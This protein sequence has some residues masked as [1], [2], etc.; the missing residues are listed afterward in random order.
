MRDGERDR[1]P[2]QPWDLVNE[3]AGCVLERRVDRRR[4]EH[5]TRPA[6]LSRRVSSRDLAL[7]IKDTLAAQEVACILAAEF[8]L[9][10]GRLYP[11]ANVGLGS[12]TAEV[13]V[14]LLE[15]Y[16][17]PG[18]NHASEGVHL[19]AILEAHCDGWDL[20]VEV[21]VPDCGETQC[22]CSCE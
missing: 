10:P 5:C 12:T 19:H 22:L 16:E 18:P 21:D 15:A 2:R 14:E 3:R 9:L 11:C 7:I 4:S 20:R 1:S 13:T 17:D 8:D 6:A